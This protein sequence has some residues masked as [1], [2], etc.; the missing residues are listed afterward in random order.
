VLKFGDD[1]AIFPGGLASPVRRTDRQNDTKC[2][3]TV[4]VQ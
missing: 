2:F 3:F 4:T 1:P